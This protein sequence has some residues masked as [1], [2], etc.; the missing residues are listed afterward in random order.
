MAIMNIYVEEEIITNP[1]LTGDGVIGGLLVMKGSCATNW[2]V[3]AKTQT[4]VWVEWQITGGLATVVKTTGN[5][6]A[7]NGE[8]ITA[9]DFIVNY[10]VVAES[11]RSWDDIQNNN[12]LEITF[13]LKS[14]QGGVE[15]DKRT[16][17]RF[18]TTSMC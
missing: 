4:S 18:C 7:I 10:D 17:T 2:M 13:I 14:S 15:V 16:F 8:T 5:Q 12:T 1:V 11:F 9:A 6:L 3:S